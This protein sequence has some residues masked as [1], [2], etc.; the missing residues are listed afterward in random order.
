MYDIGLYGHLVFDTVKDIRT[1]NDIGGIANVWK[2]LKNINSKL[3]IHISPTNIGNSSIRI[4]RENSERVC[5]SE[6]NI[7]EIA[8]TI[9][10]SK[11]NHIA[12]INEIVNKNF[13][14]K[15]DNIICA[16]ICSGKK[17][18][19]DYNIDYLF[20]SIEDIHLLN[21]S[22][23]ISNIVAHSAQKSYSN[24]SKYILDKT[25][26]LSNINVLGAG[27]CFAAHYLYGLLE[28]MSECECIKFAHDKTTDYLRNR[29]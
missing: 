20:V 21:T 24:N 23:N 13:I 28:Q 5:D 22:N 15:L 4:D 17:Y 2:S 16:D 18:S 1:Y 9:K 26:I 19:E 12:Y 3:K 8:P 7:I 11:I 6:L 29:R 27:D 14:S 25:K 10:K